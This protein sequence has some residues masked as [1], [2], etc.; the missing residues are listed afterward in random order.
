MRTPPQSKN[1]E[2]SVMDNILDKMFDILLFAT[3]ATCFIGAMYFIVM[4][5]MNTIHNVQPITNPIWNASTLIA[6][7]IVGST[8]FIYVKSIGKK[9]R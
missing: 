7:G 1:R 4:A 6:I 8:F 3:I 5:V 2:R 9:G